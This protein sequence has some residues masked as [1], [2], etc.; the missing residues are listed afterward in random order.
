MRPP[1]YVRP[2]LYSSPTDLELDD[3]QDEGAS[4]SSD[5]VVR[6]PTP[7]VE[8][9]EPLLD[10]DLDLSTTPPGS[11]VSTSGPKLKTPKSFRSLSS[12]RPDRKIA[13]MEKIRRSKVSQLVDKLAVTSEPGLTNAQLMLTNYDLK[14][15]T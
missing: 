7:Q 13:I 9:A 5:S 4:Q 3:I 12:R 2:L 8:E 11:Y 15:G 14:P 6:H 1:R 10:P